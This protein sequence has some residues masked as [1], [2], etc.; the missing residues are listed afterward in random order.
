MANEQRC[1]PLKIYQEMISAMCFHSQ[2]WVK[3]REGRD[4]LSQ[5]ETLDRILAA[6]PKHRF[7]PEKG[8]K[9]TQTRL[10]FALK[11]NAPEEVIESYRHPGVYCYLFDD[12]DPQ[13][14]L[15]CMVWP[16][17]PIGVTFATDL[18]ECWAMPL[19]ERLKVA[20]DYDAELDLD[21]S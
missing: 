14:Q 10:D 13:I 1:S 2:Y 3:P 20:L 21:A 5:K 15:E 7:D 17:Q 19:L 11:F 6:F 8:R 4:Y 18:H 12:V 16:S 9:D